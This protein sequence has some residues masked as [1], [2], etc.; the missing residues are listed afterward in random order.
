MPLRVSSRADAFTSASEYRL[1][2]V[3]S[4]DDFFQASEDGSLTPYRAMVISLSIRACLIELHH[5]V[6]MFPPVRR[7]D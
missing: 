3:S 4:L 6:R 7:T 1:F 2:H 5:R